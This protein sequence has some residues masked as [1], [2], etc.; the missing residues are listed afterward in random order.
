MGNLRLHCFLLDSCLVV[1]RGVTVR[2]FSRMYFVRKQ[3]SPEKVSWQL[4]YMQGVQSDS[5]QQ[6]GIFP[7]QE[8]STGTAEVPA[9]AKAAGSVS[10]QETGQQETFSHA[11]GVQPTEQALK[12]HNPFKAAAA[13]GTA[14]T[15]ATKQS[16]EQS[17]PSQN[18]HENKGDQ[19]PQGTGG[20]SSAAA[21]MPRLKIPLSP[22]PPSAHGQ[23]SSHRP[24]P[25]SSVRSRA[26]GSEQLPD[27]GWSPRQVGTAE[28]TSCPLCTHASMRCIRNLHP[29]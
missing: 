12:E 28:C 22:R 17:L 21:A 16:L 13:G 5:E 29:G 4:K 27:E 25:D 2:E 24:P 20:E 3:C 9:P 15:A 8:A 6:N 14:D 7:V 10:Q 23:P 1:S 11:A 18:T 19:G 26:H